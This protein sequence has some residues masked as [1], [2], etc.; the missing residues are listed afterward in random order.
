MRARLTYLTL[1]PRTPQRVARGIT[2]A[3]WAVYDGA[4]RAVAGAAIVG[5]LVLLS[6]YALD[7]AVAQAAAR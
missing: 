1:S 6:L 7:G 5:A 4:T 2:R 3:A